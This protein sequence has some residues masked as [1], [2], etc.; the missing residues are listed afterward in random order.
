MCDT[1]VLPLSTANYRQLLQASDSNL[2][3]PLLP[4]D[5]GRGSVRRGLYVYQ[6]EWWLQHF[7]AQ[8]FL[9]VNYDEVWTSLK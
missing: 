2:L 6:I 5:L 3:Q 1:R 4:Q 9:I 7:P 8:Q